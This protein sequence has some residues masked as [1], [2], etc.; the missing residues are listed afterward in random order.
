[1]KSLIFFTRIITASIVLV[2]CAVPF[3]SL[4]QISISIHPISFRLSLNPGDEWTGSVTVVNPNE[5][6]LGVGPEKERLGGGDE[7]SISLLGDEQSPQELVS[8]IS[9]PSDKMVLQTK[10]RRDFPFSINVPKNAPPGGHYAA[11]LFRA[12]SGED[13]GFSKSGVGVSG[14]VGA[15]V[16]VE[17]SGKVERAG[18]M[19]DMEAPSFL[20]KGPIEVSFKVK[21]TGNTH[22]SPEGFVSANEITGRS[23]ETTWEPRVVFPGHDRTFKVSF[24]KK[25]WFGPVDV[26]VDA[27][28][29]DGTPI[30]KISKTVWIFPWQE[31]LGGL[32]VILI[33][34]FGTRMLRKNFKIVKVE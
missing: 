20:S 32:V 27:K 26:S 28:F 2:F 5:F 9:F 11:V 19:L 1:M 21:N 12:L 6:S 3:I 13:D 25:Y 7:G 30:G 8:W 31:F 18:E 15:L 17:V 34:A 24:E 33:L 10:E 29:S 16:L 14:R 22:F 23:E 4:A